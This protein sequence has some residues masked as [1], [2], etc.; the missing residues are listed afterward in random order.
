[1]WRNKMTINEKVVNRRAIEALRAGVPNQD[2]V[3]VLGSSQPLLEKR[4]IERLK[5]AQ[6]SFAENK[7]SQGILLAGDFGTGKSHLLEHF[8]SIALNANFVC[9][10]IVIS[11]ETPLSHPLKLYRSAIES[12]TVPGRRG[13]ALNSVAYCLNPRSD[14]YAN[15]YKY[16][17]SP[18]CDISSRFAAT[19]YLYE[20]AKGDDEIRDRIIRFWA[21]DPINISELKRYL[22][23]AGE[24]A[25]Y[26]I[27]KVTVPELALQRFKFFPQLI[28]A[29][30]F[31]GWVLLVDEAELIGKYSIRQ[32]ARSYSELARFMG[33]LENSSIPGL[34]SVFAITTTFES[35]VLEQ[36]NDIEKIPAKF[37]ES[38]D[39]E[40]T[41]MGSQ[42]V[43]GMQIIQSEKQI[44]E[45]LDINKIQETYNK[46]LSIYNLAYDWPPPNKF[47]E[48]DKTA[49]IRQHIKRWITE[50]DLRRFYPEYDPVI[51]STELKPDLEEDS[52]IENNEDNE[53]ES[54]NPDI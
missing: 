44:L 20:Y 42:A 8:K 17:N 13:N 45:P 28:R 37:G 10:K 47:T 50:W 24:A 14:G 52:A 30:G 32:R 46:L 36:R 22:K 53:T 54:I 51:E 2:A 19:L 23:E 31:S 43:R 39:P 35:E 27:D 1:M 16:V 11:K 18:K 40:E 9:S 41:L 48:L 3:R 15:L 25:T 34:M 38:T 33:K 12:A 26:R 29:A 21:G 7:Q 49:R 5:S 6:Q 4:F